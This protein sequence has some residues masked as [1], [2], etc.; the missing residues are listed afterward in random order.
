[1]PLWSKRLISVIVLVVLH[2]KTFHKNTFLFPAFLHVISHSFQFLLK[3]E[4]VYCTL[5]GKTHNHMFTSFALTCCVVDILHS[6][7]LH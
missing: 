7:V 1:M 6:C 5:P 2:F 3:I 4:V